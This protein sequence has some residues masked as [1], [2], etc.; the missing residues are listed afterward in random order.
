MPT[1]RAY[2][3]NEDNRVTSYRPL[4][5]A[6]DEEALET[7]SKL[8]TGTTWSLASR[9]RNRPANAELTEAGSNR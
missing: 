6:S 4:E 5:A 2:L 9:P 8:W 1:Y 3:I 7:A